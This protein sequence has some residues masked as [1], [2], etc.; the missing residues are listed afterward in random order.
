MNELKPTFRKIHLANVE[1]IVTYIASKMYPEPKASTICSSHVGGRVVISR[2][3]ISS[4][5]F[6]L[7][8]LQHL[9]DTDSTTKSLSQH[10]SLYSISGKNN[11]IADT[12]PVRDRIILLSVLDNIPSIL[13]ILFFYFLCIRTFIRFTS[14]KYFIFTRLFYPTFPSFFFLFVLFQRFRHGFNDVTSYDM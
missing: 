1:V 5:S 7:S 14:V 4:H 12:G 3:T 8:Y 6:L 13:F 9:A 10:T 11:E 2:L